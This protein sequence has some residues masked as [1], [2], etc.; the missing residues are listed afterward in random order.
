MVGQDPLAQRPK[1]DPFADP[2]SMVD[3]VGKNSN[4][5][6]DHGVVLSNR[7]GGADLPADR[8]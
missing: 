8:S 6:R 2:R 5:V 7:R 3:A 4:R 1:G